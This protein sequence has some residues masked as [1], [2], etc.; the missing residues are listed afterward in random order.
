MSDFVYL[1][2]DLGMGANKVCG[3][4]GGLQVV[5]HVSNNG[6]YQLSDGMIGLKS[7]RRPMH[8]SSEFGSF[9]IGD[10]AHEHGRPVESL[11]F[12][13]L[14]GAPEMRA[15]L[16]GTLAQYQ[17]T[18]GGFDRPI[19]MM[20]GLPLQMMMGEAAKGYQ[21][22]VKAWLKGFH[23]F[24]ADGENMKFEVGQVRL[25]SQPVGALFDFVLD[26]D[27]SPIDD[28]AEVLMDEVGVISVGFNTLELLVVRE[29][30]AVERFTSGNTVGVRRLL[31]LVNRDGLWSL[32]ELDAKLRAGRLRE[33]LKSVMPIWAREVNGEIE[34][35]WS[36]T[37][38]R[39]AKVLVVGGGA[40][41]LKDTLTGQFG[42]K[43]WVSSDPVMSIARGLYKLSVMKR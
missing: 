19:S 7:K 36:Q 39:F 34:K 20:V 37:Y 16:Y 38:K 28:R 29:Q 23:K 26:G 2:E 18:Y 22:A 9:Y 27:G 25:T 35:R 43:V 4:S 3:A 12:D 30:G 21:S 13:R 11:D 32:G 31:E 6:S 42:T 33:E 5:S 8:I 24:E 41:L 40:L 17:R 10:G 14:T 1:G 15:L